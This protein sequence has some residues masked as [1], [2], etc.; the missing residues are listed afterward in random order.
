[1]HSVIER[2]LKLDVG[3]RFRLPEL[4]GQLPARTFV[5]VYYDTPDHRLARHGVTVRCRTE[6]RRPRWQVKLRHDAA[7]LELELDAAGPDAD[8]DL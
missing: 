2:E 8:C 3:P 4:P 7:R 5:S 1:M 6:K